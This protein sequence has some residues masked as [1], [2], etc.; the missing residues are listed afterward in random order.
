MAWESSTDDIDAAPPGLAVEGP[1]VVPDGEAGEDAVTLPL[2]QHV[3]AVGLEFDSTDAGMSE[4]DA[5]EDT[6]PRS[7]K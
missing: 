2:Q 7:S 6:S 5:A 3:A 4:K 1:H